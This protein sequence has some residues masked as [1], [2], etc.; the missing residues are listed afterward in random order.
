MKQND[1]LLDYYSP[2]IYISQNLKVVKLHYQIVSTSVRIIS[3]KGK[4][5]DGLLLEYMPNGSVADYCL[6]MVLLDN[7]SARPHGLSHLHELLAA[8][9]QRYHCFPVHLLPGCHFAAWLWFSQK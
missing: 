6:D 7:K 1:E 2:S 3:F 5:E 9:S 8:L 4:H